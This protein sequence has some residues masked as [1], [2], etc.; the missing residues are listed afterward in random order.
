ML[1]ET[2]L[3]SSEGENQYGCEGDFE[4]RFYGLPL[5]L[6]SPPGESLDTHTKRSV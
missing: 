2:C 4:I 1:S 6:I 5:I 3:T